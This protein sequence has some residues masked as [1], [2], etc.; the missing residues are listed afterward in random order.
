MSLHSYAL[1]T[2]FALAVELC[3]LSAVAAPKTEPADQSADRH[4]TLRV[5]PMLKEKCFGCHGNDTANIRGE[6]TMLTREDLLQG[7]ES[8]EP[9]IIPGNAEESVLFQAVLWEGYEMPPKE[10]DRLT[11]EQ[12]EDLRVWINAGAPWPDE[13]TQQKFRE[14]DWEVETN[15]DGRLWRTSGGTSEEW[16]SRRYNPEEMWAF[17]QVPQKSELLPES[18]SDAEVI[19]HFIN[20]RLAAADVKPAD[21]AEPRDLLRRATYDLTGLPPTP[22]EV[23]AFVAAW[24]A[25][26][27]QAW[28]HLID[29]LLASPRYGERWGRHWLDVT[30]YAD[31]G[32]MSNDYER[33]NVWRYRDYV[34]RA[35]NEDK[36]YNEFIVEQLA[37]DE[38]A[39]ESVRE[40]TGGGDQ[41]VFQTQM[42][43]DYT[44]EEAEWI[45]ATGFL[46][47]G[48][49]DNAMIEAEEARQIY[50]DDVVN[51]TGQTFLAQT[52]R[53]CKCH[54][55]KFDPI[56]T[57]DYYR[58]YSAFS[59]THMAE[60]PVPFLKEENRERFEEQKAHVERMLAFAV[61]EKNKLIEKQETAARKWFEEHNLPYKNEQERKNLPDEEKP[62]RHVGL[63]HVEQ[64]Q[65]KV[66][67]QDEWI[68][69]RRLER[70]QPMAQ[71]VYS[72]AD[73]P[74]SAYA[75][76]LRIKR[77]DGAKP[78]VN[79]ILTGGALTALG[80][81]VKPGVL[82][83]LGLPV[84]ASQEDPYVVTD[85]AF[86]RRLQL[87]RWIAHPDNGLTT[88]AIVN[89][90]WQWHFGTGLAAN[91]NNFG[92]KGAKPTH[93]EL[94]D[95]LARDFVENGWQFKQLHRKIMLSDTYRRSSTPAEAEKVSEV[96]P[97]N[98]LL[99]F[100]P[101]RRLTAEEVRDGMLAIT[102]ELV[103]CDGGL[104]V[105]PE[106][107]MEVALQP[108]MIQFSLAPAYQPSATPE[109]RNRRTVYAY[110]VRGQ[111]DPFTELFNQPNPNESCE[112]R[113]SAAVTPQAF[114]MLNSDVMNDRSIALAKRLQEERNT[115]EARIDRAFRLVFGRHA[116]QAEKQQLTIY[117]KDMQD[118]HQQVKPEPVSYP[119]EITRSLVEEF[120]GRPFEY[121]EILPIFERYQPDS[122]PADVSAETRALA[123]LCLLLLNTNEFMY[124]E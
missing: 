66:R 48:P 15:E 81:A 98:E 43:G 65:L 28:E 123:D 12:I 106:I 57:R 42:K 73:I 54:D 16:T 89:R 4:F 111:A 103:H 90:V 100:F 87:A 93:P 77:K 70:F 20:Q 41:K 10:N 35:F 7:G 116:S 56:P 14:A 113:E 114:T 121:Q 76:K 115:T 27:D 30:R 25:D 104:P 51:I 95:Y 80:E 32:G 11:A 124:V 13:A 97:N 36:P 29:R 118:Y 117:V 49:W 84:N 75:K 18:V 37:G 64:G 122:K 107:N 88:R 38:L 17:E 44:P 119:T 105:M 63:D 9:S 24:E 108:R 58:I 69:T 96:D 78:P 79:H 67:E 2:C 91:S 74:G 62:P 102:G 31:T 46:R 83:V 1:A 5:L 53:C 52:L 60:R 68:W 110:H 92:A 19:D 34:I 26:A 3:C 33:S 120:S 99:S 94:L 50:L 6:Y 72:A 109:E 22:D 23:D 101:R 59:T 85:D 40:R 39:D 112:I 71:S 8:G 55:H 82:S 45:V 21:Q 61:A 47:I 86:G